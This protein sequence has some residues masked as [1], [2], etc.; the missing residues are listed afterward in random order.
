MERLAAALMC[1]FLAPLL[2]GM[3]TVHSY[4]VYTEFLHQ[5]EEVARLAQQGVDVSDAVD[6][7]KEVHSY[8]E[9]N[10]AVDAARLLN[11]TRLRIDAL[12]REAPKI[13]VLNN[14]RKGVAVAALASIP[15]LTYFLLPRL[16]LYLWYKSRR[17]WLVKHGSTR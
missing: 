6:M 4:D 12:E 13:I 16:Y 14:L 2:L 10:R 7:L 11:V 8:L 15:I 3:A 9:E 17:G 5:Y 1:V